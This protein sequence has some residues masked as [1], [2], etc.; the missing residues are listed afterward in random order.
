[1]ASISQKDN[2]VVENGVGMVCPATLGYTADAIEALKC[3]KVV[4][5]PTYTLYGFACDAWRSIGLP[6]TPW[7]RN[8]WVKLR[9]RKNF[10]MES[11]PLEDRIT[12]LSNW[13]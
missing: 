2:N 10:F 12:L 11:N 5:V 9:E 1:M 3:G 7:K 4:A 13:E 8:E 6:V